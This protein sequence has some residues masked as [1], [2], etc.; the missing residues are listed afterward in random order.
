MILAAHDGHGLGRPRIDEI[1]VR[2]IPDDNAFIATIL[3]GA[4]DVTLG[5]SISFEQGL[6]VR[7]QWP[8]GRLEIATYTE[9]KIWPQ[10]VNANPPVVADVRFRK[11]LM[12]AMNRQEMTDIIMAGT[13]PV[14][15]S[16]VEPRVPEYREVQSAAFQYEF[17]PRRTIQMIE[18]IGY[19]R[20]SDGIFRDA[21][22][23]RLTVCSRLSNQRE[24]LSG[25]CR[26]Y[27]SR[28]GRA[29]RTRP[30]GPWRVSMFLD[31]CPDHPIRSSAQRT[32]AS[33]VATYSRYSSSV[34]ASAA[35]G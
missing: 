25:A 31:V 29:L 4:V 12:H 7:D 26:R 8:G 5:Q 13:S 6:Q 14:A 15:H 10:F 22:G 2:F 28:V 18:G 34:G 11:A 17:D 1:E 16:M 35:P 3:A 21:P 19:T 27:G 32:T 30:D 23:Q 33:A 9:M 24:R 20:A